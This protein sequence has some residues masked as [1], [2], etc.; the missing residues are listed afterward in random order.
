MVRGSS[1]AVWANVALPLKPHYVKIRIFSLLADNRCL[2]LFFEVR[3]VLAYS[4]GQSIRGDELGKVVNSR[5]DV[6]LWNAFICTVS[7]G[8]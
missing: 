6:A 7:E 2:I 3:V 1:P 8:G 4:R 5:E